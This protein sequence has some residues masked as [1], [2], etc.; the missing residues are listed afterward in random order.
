MTQ[1]AAL[2][3]AARL[4]LLDFDG[5]TCH[6]FAGYPAHALAD[7]FRTYL[8]SQDVPVVGEPP[9]PLL[10]YADAV[11]QHGELA[12]DIEAWLTR[13]ETIAAQ[14]AEPTPGCRELLI[15]AA[16]IGLPV[17]II[18]NNSEAAIRAYLDREHLA[19][20][21]AGVTGRPYAAPDRMKP[22]P[23]SIHHTARGYT[24]PASACVLIGDSV[25]DIDAACAAGCP[26]IG[27]A[28]KAGKAEQLGRA[29]AT[30]VVEDMRTLAAAIPADAPT[31]K[32]RHA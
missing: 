1:P 19:D 27:F 15:A 4:I 5:P 6:L 8:R 14:R 22:D 28:N 21:V 29:G 26:S 7:D 32:A 12:D 30:T 18:S 23:W 17:A 31:G 11:R 9:D 24:L 25:T 20:Y 2:F 3:A 16:R 10:I 13:A